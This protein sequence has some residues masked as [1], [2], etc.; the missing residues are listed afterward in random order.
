MTLV[1]S[2]LARQSSDDFRREQLARMLD[3]GRGDLGED[4]SVPV[5]VCACGRDC[6]PNTITGRCDTCNKREFMRRSR[7]QAAAL[8]TVY[9]GKANERKNAKRRAE[10]LRIAILRAEAGDMRN[11]GTIQG[12][13]R[14]KERSL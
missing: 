3:S 1:E 8:P 4:G 13:Q 11:L 14:A 7:G 5:K 10:R 9:D 12:M 6:R 2:V